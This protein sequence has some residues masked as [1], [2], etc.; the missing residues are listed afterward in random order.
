MN[1]SQIGQHAVIRSWWLLRLTFGLVFV[2]AGADKFFNLI[3]QWSKYLSPTVLQIVPLSASQLMM[4]AG[5][6]EV[7]LGILILFIA[8]RLGAYLTAAWLTAIAINLIIFGGYLDIAVRDIVMAVG[9]L[10]LAWLDE[11]IPSLKK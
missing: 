4:V 6:V 10:A 8:T 1:I 5:I 7:I 3:T 9:A 2:V 11:A